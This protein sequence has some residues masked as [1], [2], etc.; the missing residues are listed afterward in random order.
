MVARLYACLMLLLMQY[1]HDRV[2]YV[3]HPVRKPELH[4]PDPYVKPAGEMDDLTC[5]RK[6]Y[7]SRS[8]LS[9]FYILALV[10]RISG[11]FCESR[12]GAETSYFT[13]LKICCLMTTFRC[14]SDILITS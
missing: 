3:R 5:Y 14:P 7:N 1:V 9:D 4:N 2:D 11:W 8:P 6:E 10:E 13:Q 12:N